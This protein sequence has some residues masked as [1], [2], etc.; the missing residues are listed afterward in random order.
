MAM[1]RSWLVK[2]GKSYNALGEKERI[3]EIFKENLRFVDEHNA[4]MK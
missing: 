1:F 2:Y 4:E 3:F